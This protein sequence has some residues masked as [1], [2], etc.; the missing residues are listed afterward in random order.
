MIRTLLEG[1]RRFVTEVFEKDRDCFTDL[2]HEQN[3]TVLW[4]GCSDSR[5]PVNTIIQSG[6]AVGKQKSV[7]PQMGVRNPSVA[8]IQLENEKGRYTNGRQ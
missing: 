5:V 3:P 6:F 1:N 4:I 2:S 8:L 7:V